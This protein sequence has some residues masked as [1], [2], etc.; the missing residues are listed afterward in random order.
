VDIRAAKEG[1]RLWST[2]MLMACA[3]I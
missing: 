3:A 1:V 2:S